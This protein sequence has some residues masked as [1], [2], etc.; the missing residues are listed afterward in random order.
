M[1]RPGLRGFSTEPTPVNVP[2]V[3]TPA[4]HDIDAPAVSF[5]ISSAVER[6]WIS[7]WPGSRTAAASRRRRPG[8]ISSALAI[9]PRMPWAAGVSSSSAPSRR[10]MRAA[11]DRHALGHRQ[12]QPYP[13]AAQTKAS[14]IPVLPEV[15]ST[16][17]VPGRIWPALSAASIIARPMRSLTEESGLKNSHLPS[18]RRG[19]RPRPRAVQAH[20]RRRADRLEDAVVDPAAELADGVP[21]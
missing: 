11:L 7:G 13:L 17:T 15:G 21:D 1:R 5:Q 20:E 4:D 3:P 18:D 2:P 14:A 16:I 6:R 9:A 12:D 10:S 19:R 8:T